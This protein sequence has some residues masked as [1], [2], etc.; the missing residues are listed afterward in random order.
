[1][2]SIQG[3]APGESPTLPVRPDS[4]TSRP[5]RSWWRV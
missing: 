2:T 4:T 1:V 5:F 3:E